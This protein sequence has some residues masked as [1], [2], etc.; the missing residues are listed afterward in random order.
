MI[1]NP[2]SSVY[3]KFYKIDKNEKKG[4]FALKSLSKIQNTLD[5]L[6][7]NKKF[8]SNSLGGLW[9]KWRFKKKNEG[10]EDTLIQY[11]GQLIMEIS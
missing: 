6:K 2:K 8:K 10:G 5:Q 11:Y 3:L 1:F 9:N 7:A 4:Q